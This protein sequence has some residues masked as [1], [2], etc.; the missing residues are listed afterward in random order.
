MDTDQSSINRN[1]NFVDNLE[2]MDGISYNFTQ[3]QSFKE[4][5]IFLKQSMN[6]NW[7]EKNFN[8]KAEHDSIKMFHNNN[9]LDF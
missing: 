2:R 7:Q 6:L 1:Y 9:K 4:S 5:N 3:P 8:C